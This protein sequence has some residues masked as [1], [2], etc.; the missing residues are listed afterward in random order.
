MSLVQKGTN[1]SLQTSVY[2]K[3]IHTNRYLNFHS[4]HH[5]RVKAAV[6]TTLK[7]RAEDLCNEQNLTRE[8]KI[9][10][11]GFKFNGYPESLTRRI[12]K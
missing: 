6:I 9:L 12:L 1:G 2:W 10:E 7:R 3:P 5:P 11:R 4:N 8:K